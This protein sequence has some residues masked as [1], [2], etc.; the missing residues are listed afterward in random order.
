MSQNEQTI[1]DLTYTSN[2]GE[3]VALGNYAGKTL[4]IVNT[5]SKCGLTPQ[6][7][8][9]QS[10]HSEFKDRGLVVIGFP[11]DQFAHQEPGDDATIEDFCRM[12]YGV[13][14]ALST[15]V[16]VNGSGAHPVFAFLKD[17]AGASSQ[18]RSSGTSPSSWWRQTGEQSSGT[19]PRPPRTPSGTTLWPLCPHRPC[20]PWRTY[21][22]RA[23]MACPNHS[24]AR[25]RYADAVSVD[26]PNRLKP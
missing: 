14:F 10:I 18:T 5:A 26:A 9:L 11:C 3:E 21:R 4:L 7:Q 24:R 20:S 25:R 13:D 16:D 6:Y 17:R 15:K 8:A 19:R 1:F 12:N 2:R 23:A 22:G